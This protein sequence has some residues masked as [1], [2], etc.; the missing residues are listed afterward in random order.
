M[1]E[2]RITCEQIKFRYKD[3]VEHENYGHFGVRGAIERNS[4]EN[5]SLI[6]LVVKCKKCRNKRRPQDK[7]GCM[8]Q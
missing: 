8:Q 6:C 2:C 7:K 5:L 1:E 4:S 3:E